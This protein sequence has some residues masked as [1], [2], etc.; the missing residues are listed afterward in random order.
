MSLR[1][2]SLVI[3]LVLPAGAASAGS[4]GVYSPSYSVWSS[5]PQTIVVETGF[6]PFHEPYP[7]FLYPYP[8]Y[9]PVIYNHPPEFTVYALDA[10]R[11]R[12]W[13]RSV[14]RRIRHWIVR[15][16]CCGLRAPHRAS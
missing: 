5:P 12:V 7:A 10:N 11:P 9:R 8:R 13:R 6:S 15:K 14:H 1:R 16:C 2:M 4:M 3:A